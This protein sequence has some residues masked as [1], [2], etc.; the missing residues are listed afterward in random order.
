MQ[1]IKK[2]G[3]GD[4]PDRTAATEGRD[5]PAP[6]SPLQ[7]SRGRGRERETF[8]VR[9]KAEGESRRPPRRG[10]THVSPRRGKKMIARGRLSPTKEESGGLT[11]APHTRP[12]PGAS[13]QSEVA[14]GTGNKRKSR[15]AAAVTAKRVS[16]VGPELKIHVCADERSVRRTRSRPCKSPRPGSQSEA[17]SAGTGQRESTLCRRG[18]PVAAKRS[19]GAAR[20]QG[21]SHL[22]RPSFQARRETRSRLERGAMEREKPEGRGSHREA[23]VCRWPGG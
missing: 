17:M 3:Y 9:S 7:R 8:L 10:V 18:G 16:A 4:A 19:S 15:R 22:Q 6:W 13:E 20:R 23:R 2:Y 21:E 12:V 14:P 5:R 1:H 11:G